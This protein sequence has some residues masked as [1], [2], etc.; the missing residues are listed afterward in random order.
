MA[1]SPC[2]GP[3]W[4]GWTVPQGAQMVIAR[5]EQWFKDRAK[6]KVPFS[7]DS[8]VKIQSGVDMIRYAGNPARRESRGFSALH[9][10]CDAN[11]LYPVVDDDEHILDLA[12]DPTGMTQEATD[13]C[14]NVATCVDAL[15]VREWETRHRAMMPGF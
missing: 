1:D 12:D 4:N 14:N 6:V 13:Y 5:L 11:M 10:F 2:F 9:D 15:I 3:S 7:T 8:G